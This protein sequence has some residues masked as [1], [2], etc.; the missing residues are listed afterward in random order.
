MNELINIYSDESCHLY[1]KDIT[2]DNRY[3]VLGGISC[4]DT[5]KRDVFER[6]KSSKL[7]H[8]LTASSEMKWTKIS[9]PKLSAYRDLIH[10][11]F[12]NP[13]LKFRALIV[14]KTQLNH[15]AFNQTHD[16]FYYKMYWQMLGRLIDPVNKYHIYLD[17]KDTQGVYKV[18]KLHDILCYPH[19]DFDK[20]IISR[21]QE[22]R[23]HEVGIMQIVD[24]LIGAISYANR[25]PE[26]GKSDAKNSIVS[27]IQERSK[28]TLKNSTYPGAS[29]FNLFHWQGR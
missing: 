19:C 29:K 8:G 18:K 22:I 1:K 28:L 7:E 4:P 11:F 24:L 20:N 2:N 12:D 25:Y 26:G 17:I 27:L 21:I 3:M 10:Y 15:D 14:D 5:I 13:D 9:K 23:S 16:D 6:I